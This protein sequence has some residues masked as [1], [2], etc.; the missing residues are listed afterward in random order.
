M[1]W[2]ND[3]DFDDASFDDEG[4]NDEAL[5]EIKKEQH[6]IYS[7]PIM[8]KAKQ[9]Y[10]LVRALVE[11]FPEE[12]DM[13]AHYREIMLCDAGIL[14]AKIAGAEGADFYTLRMENAVQIKI[15]AK[16]LIAQTSGLK[17]LGISEPHYLQ[18]LRDEIED[19][20]LLFVDWVNTFDR[21]RD[22]Q[23]DWGLFY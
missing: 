14:G 21:T 13:A 17:M 5:H 2:N 23:D 9:I 10:E 20:R 6:R 1:F 11:T 19:F 12:D 18:L 8:R 3:E 4:A 16:N 7:M 22:F 15:A